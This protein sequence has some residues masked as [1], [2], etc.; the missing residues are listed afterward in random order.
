MWPDGA[1]AREEGQCLEKARGSA[2]RRS[3]KPLVP[4][5]Q[6]LAN[7]SA[8]GG[9]LR[10][11]PIHFRQNLSSRVPHIVAWRLPGVA[12]PSEPGNLLE[13]E[14]ESKRVPDELNA[15]NRCVLVQPI[16]G[17]VSGRLR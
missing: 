16:A 13:R 11:V 4:I 6:H 15:Q 12:R 5:D 8:C 17:A 7:R 9:Q 2:R 3:R 1:S 14:P 10:D